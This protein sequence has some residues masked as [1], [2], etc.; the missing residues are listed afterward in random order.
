MRDQIPSGQIPSGWYPDPDPDAPAGQQR[1]WDGSA[2]TQRTTAQTTEPTVAEPARRFGMFTRWGIPALVG[3]L[4]FLFG[5]GVGGAPDADTTPT[6]AP[7]PA[8]TATVT[9]TVP[10]AVPQDQ[11]DALGERENELD[12]QETDLDSRES[13]LDKREADLDAREAASAEM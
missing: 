4:A 3:V 10:G 1:Y 7:E 9:A 12:D 6:A 2:W 8:T 13:E 11:L 5:I